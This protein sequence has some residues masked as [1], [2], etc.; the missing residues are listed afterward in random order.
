MRVRENDDGNGFT[1]FPWCN[2]N[3]DA[4]IPDAPQLRRLFHWR[5]ANSGTLRES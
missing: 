1:S 4:A 5:D 2:M 3:T